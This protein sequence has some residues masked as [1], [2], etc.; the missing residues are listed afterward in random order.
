MPVARSC[1][2]AAI[3]ITYG[4]ASVMLVPIAEYLNH[5]YHPDRDYLEGVSVERN[6]GEISHSDAQ[7]SLLVFIRTRMHGF[8][9]GVEVR[10][11]VRGERFR[12]PDV[13]IMRGGKPEGRIIMRP[14]EAVVEVFHPMTARPT[15]KTRSTIIWRLVSPVSGCFG[16]RR[17]MAGCI[18][19]T[20]RG[21]PK[22]GC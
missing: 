9:A 15:F 3:T 8:W 18:P 13:T 17:A 21:R 6:V 4:M 10:V 14:P 19:T 20:A 1:S 7:S 12:I 2:R 16:Q 11:Q 5:T 22:T